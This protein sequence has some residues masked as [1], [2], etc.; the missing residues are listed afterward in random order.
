MENDIKDHVIH[1]IY[2][3]NWRKNSY[4]G[5]VVF[6]SEMLNYMLNNA[7]IKEIE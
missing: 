3:F 5:I 4:E 7:H 2:E 1:L 6:L